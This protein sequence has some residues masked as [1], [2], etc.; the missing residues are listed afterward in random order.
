VQAFAKA[1]GTD[2]VPI[3]QILLGP[4]GS[5]GGDPPLLLP[6]GEYILRAKSPTSDTLAER[7]A[8]VK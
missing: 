3:D 4:G 6:P 2:A 1:E 7:P 8:L 5:D